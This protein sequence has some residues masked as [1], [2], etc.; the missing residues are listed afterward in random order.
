[1]GK[2]SSRTRKS[3]NGPQWEQKLREHLYQRTR[4]KAIQ[5]Y[6]SDFSHVLFPRFSIPFTNQF[7]QTCWLHLEGASDAKKNTPLELCL[8]RFLVSRMLQVRDDE[9][10]HFNCGQ[11]QQR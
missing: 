2:T 5:P 9:H 7:R 8:M 10:Q 11:Y 1:M 4:V 6:K 3:P